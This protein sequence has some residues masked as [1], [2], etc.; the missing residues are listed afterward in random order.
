MSSG[1]FHDRM[2]KSNFMDGTGR[3]AGYG[4]SSSDPNALPTQVDVTTAIP[5]TI[6]DL[7]DDPW[8]S[9]G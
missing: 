3:V 2:T 9:F 4:S 1:E 8:R 7:K 5:E 6:R